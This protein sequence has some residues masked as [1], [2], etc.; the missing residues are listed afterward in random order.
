MLIE[1]IY[2]QDISDWELYD[3]V[4]NTADMT[5]EEGANIMTRAAE[6]MQPMKDAEART[7]KMLRLSLAK[8]AESA[9]RKKVKPPFYSAMLVTCPRDGVLTLSGAVDSRRDREEAERIAR[10]FDGVDEIINEIQSSV[11]Y[12]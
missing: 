5:A 6:K 2:H 11:F 4:L 7:R 10:S 8:R 12:T 1:N 9:I 3:Q